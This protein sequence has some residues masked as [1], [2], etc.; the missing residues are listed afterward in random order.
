MGRL[1]KLEQARQD[2]MDYA[3]RLFK[4]QGIEALERRV[5]RNRVTMAPCFAEPKALDEF[6][7][8]VKENCVTTM[9]CITLL[10]LHDEFGFGH[11]RLEQFQQRFETKA[12]CITADLCTYKDMYQ[13]LQEETGIQFTSE[14]GKAEAILERMDKGLKEQRNGR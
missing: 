2:G 10:T 12:E 7:I 1:S 3:Y 9:L 11:K 4:E 5:T 8:A 6:A 13:V 14:K